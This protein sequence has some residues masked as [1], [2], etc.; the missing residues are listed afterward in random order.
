MIYLDTSFLIRALVRGSSQDRLL[1]E[2]IRA[3]EPLGV[4][5]VVW[6]EFLCGPVR[7]QEVR[8]AAEVVAERTDF[9]ED[10]AAIAARLFNESGRRRGSLIDCMI[11]A[12]AMA[13]DAP[14]ATE[15]IADFRRLQASGLRILGA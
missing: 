5:A 10:H 7:E 1:R 3:G 2:W 9:T 4:S 12:T 8:W 15:N 6:A 13:V 14:L 11:A